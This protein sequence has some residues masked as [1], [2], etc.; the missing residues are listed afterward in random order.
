MATYTK[1]IL[2][3]GS[4]NGTGILVGNAAIASGTIIHTVPSSVKD[5]LTLWATNIHTAGVLLTIGF[6]ATG[7]TDIWQVTIPNAAGPQLIVAD[8]PLA[9]GLV[10]RATAATASVISIFGSANRIT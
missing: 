7:A 4:A 6:G 8:W 1:E 10:V 9:T 3:G 2:T 5:I